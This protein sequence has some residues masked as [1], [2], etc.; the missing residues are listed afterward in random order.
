MTNY[1]F[2]IK[3]IEISKHHVA[4]P[5]P[6]PRSVSLN[7]RTAAL[8]ITF[9]FVGYPSQGWQRNTKTSPNKTS[10]ILLIKIVIPLKNLRSALCQ[11]EEK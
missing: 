9:S 10:H 11:P 8:E 3:Y 7:F 6:V 4:Q 5:R 1:L 2:S